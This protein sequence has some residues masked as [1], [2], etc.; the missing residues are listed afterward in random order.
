MP[1]RNLLVILFVALVVVSCGGTAAAPP[2]IQTVIVPQTVPVPQTV[3]IEKAA[4]PA[5]VTTPAPAAPKAQPPSAVLRILP[6]A[7]GKIDPNAMP[8]TIKIMTD[9][10][11]GPSD[12]TVYVA[13]SGLNNVSV[14]VPVHLNAGVADSKNPASKFAWTLTA[15]AGSKAALKDPAASGTTEFTPDVVGFYRVSVVASNDAGSST[16]AVQVHADEYI[17][18][19]TGNCKNCHANKYDEWT[20]TGHATKFTRGIGDH[21]DATNKSYSETCIAC[22]TVGYAPGVNNGGFA[23]IQA[24]LKWVFPD[25]KTILTGVGNWDKV[26]A[27]LKNVANIQCENCHGPAKDHATT[28]A[29]V[30]AKSLDEGVCDQCHGVGGHHTIGNQFANAAHGDKSATPWNVPIGPDRQECVRCHSGAGYISFL[31]NPTN[32]AAWTNTKQT[33][34]CAVCHD[35]HS[36]KNTAQLRIIGTPVGVPFEAKDVGL[37]ATCEECHNNRTSPADAVKGSYPHYSSAAQL[38]SN[39]AGVDYGATIPDSPHGT[40]VGIAPVPDPSDK[41]GKTLLFK[42]VAPGPCVYCHMYPT[43]SD[44]KDPNYLKVGGHSFNTISPDGKFDYTAACQTCHA[45][46]KDFN[47]TAKADY[48]GNGKVEGV[49]DEVKGLLNVLWKALEAK[50]LKKVDTGYPYAT[51][52]KDAD[53]HVKNAWYNYRVVY[54]VMW[55][56]D[57]PG[58]QGASAA[59]HNF[60]RAVS[61]LQL[62][63]KDLTGQDVPGATLL[64]SGK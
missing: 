38:L 61:L 6:V 30:M 24:A 55:G 39:V 17:G 57:S 4:P 31:D 13:A 26:P 58:N 54:G 8:A 35:P 11:V 34:T 47:F 50:G 46:M 45:G 15:P 32:S 51:V 56:S 60:N 2:V 53:D 5:A 3:I 29:P 36:D 14:G 22:H 9:T 27:E 48:D 7:G 52:P 62:S 18:V 49:Q 10:V 37:S 33:V 23:A 12:A 19:N 41:T 25:A 21:T 20:Q 40:M 63:Y 64:V 44:A 16:A 42:G 59:I 28:G 43:I 1:I